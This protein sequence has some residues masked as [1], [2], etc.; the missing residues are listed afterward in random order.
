MAALPNLVVSGTI[1]G[2]CKPAPNCSWPSLIIFVDGNISISDM[3]V[4][5]PNAPATQPYTLLG[6]TTTVLID[7][8]RVMGQYPTNATVERIAMSGTPD[9]TSGFGFNVVNGVFFAG[10]LP[11]SLTPFDFYFLSGTFR[12]SGSSFKTMFDGAAA[13]FFFKDSHVF[14]GGSPLTGNVFE[15]VLVGVDLE[16][17]ENSVLD[18]SHNIVAAGEFASIWAIPW[19]PTS[20]FCRIPT[21]PSLYLIHDNSVEPPGAFAD[22]IFLQDDPTNKWIY[23]LVY[24]NTVKMQTV[25]C[26]GISAYWTKGTTIV[27][28]NISGNGVDGIGI[29]DGTYVAVLRN[30][31]TGFNPNPNS[32]LAQIMLDG[33]LLGLPDTSHSTVVCGTPNDT[34]VNLGTDNQIIGCQETAISDAGKMS[35]QPKLLKKKLL[36]F[37]H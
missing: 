26:G 6:S 1:P 4:T 28:N 20:S 17:D 23:A 25:C 21:R 15:D 5:A 30:N 19:C 29:W 10:E 2:E 22:G 36:T 13:G 14:I 24:N 32:G 16:S 9:D 37:L 3:T 31:V 35:S 11:K 8:V 18:V 12:V 33:S 34:V 7:L 27:N